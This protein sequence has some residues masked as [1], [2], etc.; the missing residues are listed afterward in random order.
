MEARFRSLPRIVVAGTSGDSGK[1]LAALGLIL[2]ARERAIP[3]VAFKKGP[4]YIDTAWLSWASG[5]PARN[6]D[7]FLMGWESA[8]WSF[9]TRAEPAGLSVIEGNR[10][11]Y[12]GVDAQGTHS[13]AELAKQLRAPVLLVVNATKATRTVAALVLGCQKL[14]PEVRIGGVILNQFGGR[15]H[16]RL[17]RGAVE[18]TCGVPVVGAV[19]R[20]NREVLLPSRHL[21]LVTPDEHPD[22]ERVRGNVLALFNDRLDL[23][24]ILEIARSAPPFVPPRALS[25]T[26]EDGHGLRIGYLKDSAFTFYYPE[27]LEAIEKSGASL[28]P[29]S[30]LLGTSA[31]D[32]VD[33]LYIGGGF[34]ETHGSQISQ[35][36]P[37][38]E[39]IRSHIANG[40]PV[41]AECGGLMLL[42]RAIN[43]RGRR[44]PMA[45]VFPVE[46][47]VCGTPQGHGYSQLMVDRL[48]PFFPP[49]TR[50]RGHEFHYSRIMG[51]PGLFLTACKVERG[52]GCG[53]ARDGMIV[54]N[55]WAS[56]THLHALATPAW[57][58]G[59]IAAARR[60]KS[61]KPLVFLPQDT[62]QS[63]LAS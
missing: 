27:N 53:A 56:Y 42:A 26:S 55:C 35:N 30:A 33:A 28:V 18:E 49:G 17:L 7:S 58:K 23:A 21:G 51:D 16:E 59:L 57:I 39:S 38:L 25:E 8:A 32:D 50:L 31:S 62:G 43:W 19:P 41:Y 45:R 13:T 5:G 46:V 6:L 10:G 48:N 3:V 20:A 24:R 14:D 44:Y 11:M 12:D 29:F 9:F 36:Q 34:P 40:L 1:T 22:V 52:T 15:R 37:F 4:D 54:N 61:A 2:L 47:E 63:A 60:F